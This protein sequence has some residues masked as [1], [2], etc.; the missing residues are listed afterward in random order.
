MTEARTE[1]MLERASAVVERLC[2]RFTRGLGLDSFFPYAEFGDI[3][4]KTA[5]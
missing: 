4:R 5:R 3:G 2:I 1:E